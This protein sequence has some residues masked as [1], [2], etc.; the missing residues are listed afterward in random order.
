MLYIRNRGAIIFITCA[1]VSLFPIFLA[2]ALV[3]YANTFDHVSEFAGLFSLGAWVIYMTPVAVFL[4]GDFLFYKT[5]VKHQNIAEH[6]KWEAVAAF[7]LSFIVLYVAYLLS[8]DL[9]HFFLQT[10]SHG[11]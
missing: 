1:I 7:F 11:I 5:A 3:A 10:L 8:I 2:S 4:M 9:V 6:E